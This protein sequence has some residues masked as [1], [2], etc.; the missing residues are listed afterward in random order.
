MP[1]TSHLLFLAAVLWC[2]LWLLAATRNRWFVLGAVAL[3]L[4]HWMLAERGIYDNTTAFPPPQAALLVP[5]AIA[6]LIAL[7]L[8]RGR[9]WLRGL[10]LFALTA[11]HALRLPVELVLHD[12][13]EAGLVPQDM[14]YSGFNFDI[15]SGLTALAMM[16]WLR[17]RR[18][19]GRSVL[20]VW[21]CCCLV[22]LVIVVTTA[23]L[24]I[25]SA[26]QRINFDQ[27][28]VLVTATPWVLLPAVLVPAVLFAHI[29]AL[30]QLLNR[31]YAPART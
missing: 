15:V 26:V 9:A 24:S 18:P 20:I 31:R 7:A 22:L 1:I 5:P 3:G 13:F 23:V 12:G 10:P 11:I 28:N 27:P 21:N 19:P 6:L 14:T 16:A 4:V 25:P 29:A 8:P 2:L 30:A 17:S